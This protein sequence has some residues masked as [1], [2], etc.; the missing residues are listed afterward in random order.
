[1]SR[2]VLRVAGR[3]AADDLG[4]EIAVSVD[5]LPFEL[6]GWEQ[7][8]QVLDCDRESMLL[9]FNEEPP[10]GE[11]MREVG[12]SLLQRLACNP[13]VAAAVQRAMEIPG[14]DRC[15]I[16][17]RFV[18]TETAMELPWETLFDDVRDTFLALEGRWPIARI[19]SQPPPQ[20][21]VE[22]FAP[23]LRLMAAMSAIRVPAEQEWVALKAAVDE[24]SLDIDLKV[25]VGE[26]QLKQRIEQEI[27]PDRVTFLPAQEDFLDAIRSFDPHILH[28]F[29]H[30]TAEKSPMLHLATRRDHRRTRPAS[31]VQVE[32]V[33]LRNRGR[34]TWLVTLNCCEGAS[35]R[36]GARSLAYLL[37]GAGF[38]AA[39]GMREPVASDDASRFTSTFY[40]SLLRDLSALDD[41]GAEVA[42]ELAASLGG[43]R[44]VLVDKYVPDLDRRQAAARHRD[45]TLPVLYVRPDPLRI[46]RV[47][48]SENV[49]EGARNHLIAELNTLIRARRE[50]HRDTPKAAIA[51][52]DG[53]IDEIVND[54]A[55]E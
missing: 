16:Y 24:C 6:P 17:V 12:R 37:I 47:A 41:T 43:P 39:V 55:S 28:L 46:R 15:A 10:S 11:N 49:P 40:R 19:V 54:L 38:P 48:S 2:I 42:I 53:K 31:S 5:E 35:D 14:D 45:W 25:L 4:E 29:C 32:P 22:V 52:I 7:P 23:P 50:L 21:A 9:Q 27:D 30:G 33:H 26:E 13:A 20:Q 8:P 36:K 18:S 3:P 51:L 44:S 34:S 1:M